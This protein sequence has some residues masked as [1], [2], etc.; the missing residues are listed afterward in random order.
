[1]AWIWLRGLGRETAHWGGLPRRVELATG[2]KV[3]PLDLPGMGRKREQS[4]PLSMS[5]LVRQLQEETCDLGPI[6]IV[7]HSLGG[8]VA[9]NWAARD[10]RVQQV[11][12][13]N[14]SS[15]LS[16][17]NK[18]LRMLPALGLL[19]CYLSK[20]SFEERE[21]KVLATVSNNDQAAAAVTA[22]W[23]E[24]ARRRPVAL[25]Q[26]V[27]Q[28]VLA[29]F[30]RLPTPNQILHCSVQVL[31]SR[32]DRLVASDCSRKLADYYQCSLVTHPEAGHDLPLD[33]PDWLLT[34]I[35]TYSVSSAITAANC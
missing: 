33:D 14:S 29:A 30:S 13:I 19:S 12:L 27:R 26:V 5:K 21:K 24:V 23:A 6:K 16:F 10:A 32:K 1:M 25:R 17:F 35:K 20:A 11:V 18:R 34:Q 31:V 2:E 15:R 7:A 4:C 22:L 9:L 28:L 8:N 3:L